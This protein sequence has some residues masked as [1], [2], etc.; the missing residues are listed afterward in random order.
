MIPRPKGYSGRSEA[1]LEGVLRH[2]EMMNQYPNQFPNYFPPEPERP[3]APPR[4]SI[5]RGIFFLVPLTIVALAVAYYFVF[6]LPEQNR[7]RLE[8]ER[9]K[10]DAAQKQAEAD[11]QQ[12]ANADEEERRRAETQQERD[13][14][15]KEKEQDA[16]TEC[17]VLANQAYWSY[18][19]LNGTEVEG[20]P[21]TYSAPQH[22]WDEAD[23][24]RKESL[25]YCYK[26]NGISP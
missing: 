2:E 1:D 17:D 14:A 4:R 20:K 19:K 24:K 8:L 3:P 16:R 15:Q 23:A 12:K 11:R 7:A 22:V 18:V 10:L 13:Q 5:G 9:A 6:A 21:G 25:D 26:K